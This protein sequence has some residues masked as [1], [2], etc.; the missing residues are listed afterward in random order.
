MIGYLQLHKNFEQNEVFT[1][2]P[3]DILKDNNQ[4]LKLMAARKSKNDGSKFLG[5]INIL[6]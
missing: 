5:L 3:K 2:R 1:N 4:F 6:T